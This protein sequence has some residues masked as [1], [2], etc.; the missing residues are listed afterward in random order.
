MT[1][2]MTTKKSRE[3]PFPIELIDQLI[4]TQET[5]Q[6]LTGLIERLLE[7]KFRTGLLANYHLW[8]ELWA[9][10]AP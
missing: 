4:A 5:A 1:D 9:G 8:A 10:A 7:R 6:L 3:N 2:A